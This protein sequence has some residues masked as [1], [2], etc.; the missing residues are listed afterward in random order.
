[1][2]YK[3]STVLPPPQLFDLYTNLKIL[4]CL[5]SFCQQ[6]LESLPLDPQGDN[7]FISYPTCCYTQLLQLTGAPDFPT[8]FHIN[9]L[10]KYLQS[11]DQSV[12]SSK[13]D[14]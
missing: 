6:C 5:H 11:N 10:I 13:G 8:T 9:I 4:P 12:S 14:Q 3:S 2:A 7:Y 1:M